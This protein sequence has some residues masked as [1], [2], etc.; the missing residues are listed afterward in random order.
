LFLI[1]LLML[2]AKGGVYAHEAT[3]GI[4]EA[5]EAWSVLPG[6]RHPHPPVGHE[7][8]NTPH[9]V[10]EDDD[11]TTTTM[12]EEDGIVIKGGCNSP[13]GNELV[14]ADWGEGF[15]CSSVRSK[16]SWSWVQF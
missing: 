15:A 12:T 11:E 8:P 13:D 14:V 5:E 3:P 6:R 7:R 4:D 10:G 2:T 9:G 16:V 1:A